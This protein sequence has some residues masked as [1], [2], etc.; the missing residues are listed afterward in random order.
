MSRRLG[1]LLVLAVGASG[2]EG[3]GFSLLDTVDIFQQS[4]RNQLDLLVVIDNSCSMVEE[5]RNV[6][7]NF[8]VLINTFSSAEVD[9]QIAVTTTDVE[10]ERFRGRLVSGD[11]EIILRGGSGELDRVEYNRQWLFEEGIALQ[12]DPEKYTPT[13]NLNVANWCQAPNDYLEGVK[14]SPGAWNPNCDGSAFDPGN[15]GVDEGPLAP[16]FGQL[17][18]T[19]IMAD[20]KGQDSTCEWFELTNLTKDTLNINGVELRD[21]GNNAV[22]FPEGARIGPFQAMVV[23]RTLDSDINCSVPVDIAVPEGF[24]LQNTNPVLDIETEDA[25]ERF[26]E[27]IAQ[28][29]Q[30][31]GIEHGLEAA[32]LALTAPVD[33]LDRG[34]LRE[35]ASLGILVVSDEDD[36]S[37]LSIQQYERAFKELKGDRAFRQDGW[38]QVNSLVGTEPTEDALDISCQSEDGVAYFASRY[39][40]LSSRTGGLAESI[41]AN[42]FQPVVQ[43]LGLQ[44]S[45]LDLRFTL[46]DFPIL[47]SLVVDLYEDADKESLVRQLEI[48]VDFTY[49]PAENAIVFTEEQIPPPEYYITATYRPLSAGSAPD[50]QEDEG[51]EE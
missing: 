11:D 6:A 41:C 1:L 16:R 10:S 5:Q 26:A 42:D 22:A 25:E 15:E 38:F 44:I 43:N 32:R 30:G 4:R 13:S 7:D 51:G 8:D 35:D 9:W 18:I 50:G 19:E 24:S 29:T 48:D 17:V 49:D 33:E 40:E 12:L 28:G 36:S 27:M 3:P 46:T 14:G 21:E 31:T 37:A 47:D 34:W 45:G 39:I 20:A 2:C 23:G